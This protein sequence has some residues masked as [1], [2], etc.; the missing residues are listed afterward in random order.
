M[1]ALI[2]TGSYNVQIYSQ[3]LNAFNKNFAI[4]VQLVEV[5]HFPFPAFSLR[6]LCL[7]GVLGG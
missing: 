4:S 1:R 3:I 5:S 7:L 2:Q 6:V